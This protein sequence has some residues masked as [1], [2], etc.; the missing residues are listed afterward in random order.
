M[1][2]R[3]MDRIT[4]FELWA[5]IEGRKTVSLEEYSLLEPLGRKGVFPESLVV[6]TCVHLARWMVTVSSAFEHTCILS[7]VDGFRFD[8]EV[9]AGSVLIASL[10][11]TDRRGDDMHC[12][13]AVAGGSGRLG[14]GHLVVSLLPLRETG[15]AE[16]ARGLWRELYAQTQRA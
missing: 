15:V 8:G 5:A 6:E 9:R 2:W 12:D 1:R 14:G 7:A 16:D 11:V 3:F 4:R 13:C 10:R